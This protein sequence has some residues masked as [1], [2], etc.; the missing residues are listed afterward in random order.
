MLPLFAAMLLAQPQTSVTARQGSSLDGGHTAWAVDCIN[1]SGGGGVASSVTVTGQV[2]IN[3]MDAGAPLN[4]NLPSGAAT[5][6]KQDTGNSSLTSIDG[7]LPALSGGKVPVDIGASI[8]SVTGGLTDTQLRATPVPVSGAVTTTPPSNA[9]SNVA[10]V[11]GIT[12]QTGT[13]T[14][15]TG[16][17]RVAVASDSSITANAGTNLN[18]SAL[19]LDATITNRTQKTQVT[20]GTRDGTVKAASTAALAT[21]TALVVAV[22]PNNSVGVTAAALPLPAGAATDSTLSQLLDGGVLARGLGPS[23][24][25][26]PI[27]VAQTGV[28]YVQQAPVAPLNPFLPRCNPVRRTGCQP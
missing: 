4:V 22:S 5:S 7:K 26:V 3:I 11:N 27:A 24:L 9:S 18:T 6:A 16:T 28:L 10:Q 20:D 23:G 15:G 14:A 13:G 12:T 2:A 1:C 8:V 17:Q 19:A 25:G 21:D